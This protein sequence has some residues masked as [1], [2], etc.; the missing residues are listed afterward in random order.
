MVVDICPGGDSGSYKKAPTVSVS[1]SLGHK[2]SGSSGSTLSRASDSPSAV[3]GS[4]S[5]QS[6]TG[7]FLPTH[8]RYILDIFVSILV[9][10]TGFPHNLVLLYEL[11]NNFL[12]D[13][14]FIDVE[15]LIFQIGY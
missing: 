2:R 4:H 8:A 1:S 9:L 6:S 3:T 14:L 5:R 7:L 15:I 12:F 13:E 11:Y 10:N